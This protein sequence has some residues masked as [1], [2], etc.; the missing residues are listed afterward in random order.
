M[1]NFFGDKEGLERIKMMKYVDQNL[2]IESEQLRSFSPTVGRNASPYR[3]T[4]L[5][6]PK[7]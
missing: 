7:K 2:G 4:N 3:I 5:H 1:V 6:S